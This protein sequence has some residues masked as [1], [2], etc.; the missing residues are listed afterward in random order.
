MYKINLKISSATTD[1]VFETVTN[2]LLTQSD[3]HLVVGK[4]TLLDIVVLK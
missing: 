4:I 3:E 2:A 1:G